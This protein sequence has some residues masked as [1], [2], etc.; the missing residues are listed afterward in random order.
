MY[1]AKLH[2]TLKALAKKDNDLGLDGALAK[3]L[4]SLWIV[5]SK[6]YIEVV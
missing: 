1:E 5:I 2:S 3:F 4:L 6:E